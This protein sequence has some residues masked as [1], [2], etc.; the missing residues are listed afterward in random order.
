[1]FVEITANESYSIAIGKRITPHP[2][3]W[4]KKGNFHYCFVDFATAD[5]ASEASKAL[6]GKAYRGGRLRVNVS[7]N[8]PRNLRDRK[9]EIQLSKDQEGEQQEQQQ[10]QSPRGPRT[11][12][13]AIASA[14]WRRKD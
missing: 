14:N 1:V 3:T 12:S 4:G 6:D 7:S 8:T 11:P 13:R 5:E 10:Q 2:G 9:T